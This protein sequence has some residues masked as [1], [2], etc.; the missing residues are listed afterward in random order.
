MVRRE[1][2]RKSLPLPLTGMIHFCCYATTP[3]PN[4]ITNLFTCLRSHGRLF[5]DF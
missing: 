3:E 4:S 2:I 1:K 5:T